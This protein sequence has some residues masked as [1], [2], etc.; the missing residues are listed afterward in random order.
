LGQRMFGWW[1]CAVEFVCRIRS[2]Y[3]SIK[4][5]FPSLD[6]HVHVR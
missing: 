2:F 6:T 3:I 4:Q 5:F 1:T